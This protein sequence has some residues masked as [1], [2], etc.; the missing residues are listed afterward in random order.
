MRPK[1]PEKKAEAIEQ[2]LH[3][4]GIDFDNNRH[5]AVEIIAKFFATPFAPPLPPELLSKDEIAGLFDT[6]EEYLG[7]TRIGSLLTIA[8]QTQ[9]MPP[10]HCTS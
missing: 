9:P 2:E 3:I 7:D 6:V 1:L 8:H 5:F 4:H 10:T